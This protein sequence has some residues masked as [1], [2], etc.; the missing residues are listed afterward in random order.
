MIFGYDSWFQPI[1]WA[2]KNFVLLKFQLFNQS[3]SF[4]LNNL[5][6]G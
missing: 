5:K 6:D 2:F 3:T 1:Q 4:G